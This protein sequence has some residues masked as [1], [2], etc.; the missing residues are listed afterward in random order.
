MEHL[1]VRKFRTA[2]EE[3]KAM[4]NLEQ[5]RERFSEYVATLNTYGPISVLDFQR[6]GSIEYRIRFIF[7]NGH[8]YLHI[9][10]DLGHMTAYN[11][12]N[13]VLNKFYSD[14]VNDPGYFESKV[15]THDRALYGWDQDKAMEELRRSLIEE[16]DFREDS[17]ELDTTLENVFEGFDDDRGLNVEDPEVRDTLES[18]DPNWYEWAPGLGKEK[19]GVIELYLLAFRLA[20][21]QLHPELKAQEG[22]I[23]G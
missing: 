19:T 23:S 15:V 13:M 17:L 9:S 1:T 14:Y 18:I 21:E 8:Y 3:I 12:N 6:P 11:Y 2:Q 20:W 10:G 16:Y 22:G 7:E 4:I 5:A